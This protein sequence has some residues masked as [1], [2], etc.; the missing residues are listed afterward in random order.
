MFKTKLNLNVTIVSKTYIFN[1][2]IE[3]KQQGCILLDNRHMFGNESAFWSV[4]FN[5]REG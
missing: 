1:D 3:S 4:N 5:S 2:E